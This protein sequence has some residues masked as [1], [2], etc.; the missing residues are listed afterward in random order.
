VRYMTLTHSFHTSWADSSGTST[1]P[2]PVNDGLNAFGE[3]VVREMN[4][5]GMM[6]DVSHVS[7]ATFFDVVRV[8]EAPII[9]SHSSCRAVADHTRNMSDEQL[10]ALA[11]NDGVILINFYPAYI[12]EQANLETKA[13]FARWKS[14]FE[15]LREQYADDPAGGSRARRE[16][17]AAH[18][19]PQTSLDVLLDH[20]DHALKVAGPDHVGLGAD[21]DGVPSMPRGMDDVTALPALTRGL[22]LRGHDEETVRKVLGENLLRAM[23][24]VEVVSAQ[25]KR[26]AQGEI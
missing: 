18:P 12:D 1:I 20:F 23:A 13:Y 2:E 7:D 6:V 3:E 26:S 14:D 22:L 24:R 5:L 4:R 17:F 16:H 9:A 8:S 21:W 11:A 25:S 15:A 19:V 10:R